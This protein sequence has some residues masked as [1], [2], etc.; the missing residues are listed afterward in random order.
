MR[1]FLTVYGHV[2]LDQIMT[3]ERFPEPNT[4]VD[5]VE[6]HRYFGGTGANIATAAAALGVPTALVSYV[7]PDLPEDFRQFMVSKGVDLSE[8]TAVDGYETS[9]VLIVTDAQESQIAYV[10]QGPMRDMGKF[11][12]K[13]YSARQSKYV[14]VSTG[15]PE[16]YLPVMEE[17]RQLGK[18]VSFDPAQEINRMW[19]RE[20]FPRALGLSSRLF[21]NRN[22]LRIAM[23]YL[24]ASSPEAV[25]GLVPEI[26]TTR[27]G[28]GAIVLTGQGSWSVPAGR[29]EKVVDPT[30]AG[31]AFRAGF[32]AGRYYGHELLESVAYGNAAASFVLEAR[33]ALTNL[34]TWDMVEERAEGILSALPR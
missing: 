28:E 11:E 34:P 19:D 2:C 20:T 17:C 25:L 33:G 6:K 13:M 14:H 3:L 29:P 15:R 30:G 22:E 12:R 5:I 32:Y 10:Y 23:R 26:I 21:C 8:M 24:D 18:E 16:Y 7:G 31:D 9:A 4:S 1:P 27:G